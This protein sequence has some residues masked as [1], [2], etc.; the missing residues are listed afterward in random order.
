MKKLL[1]WI[2]FICL[3]FMGFAI[4]QET[5]TEPVGELGVISGLINIVKDLKGAETLVII[6]GV[7]QAV[8]LIGRS[9]WSKFLGKSKL[10]IIA[11]ASF[12]GVIVTGL[13][14]DLSWAE[15]LADGGTLTAFQVLLNQVIKQFSKSE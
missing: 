8:L 7:I 1:T 12:A 13:T 9:T 5:G 4:A 11:L 6:G 15:I 2:T 14:Q 3:S 10:L